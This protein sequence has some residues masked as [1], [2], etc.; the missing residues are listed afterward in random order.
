M[1]Q[2]ILAF[3]AGSRSPF[4]S[5]AV[6]WF[7]PCDYFLIPDESMAYKHSLMGTVRLRECFLALLGSTARPGHCPERD[8]EIPTLM[9][10]RE[11]VRPQPFFVPRPMKRVVCAEMSRHSTL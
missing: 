8:T 5:T 1:D 11:V 4:Y 6:L 3:P 7:Y 9:V 10:R 2:Q